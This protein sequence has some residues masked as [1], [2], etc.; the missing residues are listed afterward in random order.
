MQMRLSADVIFLPVGGT[1]TMTAAEAAGL[2]NVIK[3]KIA[4]P[5][6]WGSIVGSLADAETFKK[7]C[8]C[9]VQIIKHE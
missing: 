4:V 3:P 2:A 9:E 6:H 8:T 7:L 1:Y 5:I